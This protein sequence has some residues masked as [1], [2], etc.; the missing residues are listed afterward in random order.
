[1][2]DTIRNTIATFEYG[3][4]FTPADFPVDLRKQATVNRVL[5]N[6]VAAGQI[7]RAS[8]G[9]FYKPKMT[10]FGELPLNIC[11]LVKDLIEK[12]G[13]TVGYLTGY[14]AFN[15]LGLTTQVPFALQIGVMNEKMAIK[16]NYYRISFI[17]Q[18]NEITKENIYLLQLLDCLRFF[19]NIPDS[20]PN[21]T[22]RRLFLLLKKLDKQQREE[23]KK[24]SLKYTP[25]ATAL[26]GAILETLNPKEDTNEM[27]NK[28]NPQ[29]FYK[30]GISDNILS[31][32]K[33]WNI[34]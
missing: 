16:R 14:T 15:E 27:Y 23:I 12:N 6:M 34:R 18:Q 5:N 10:E 9:R 11:Q 25:Q 24:L 29:T 26:L 19:K 28:L 4:V 31:N 8:K 17:K 1:M 32:Q 33:K 13:K 21:E 22:C 2:T 30:L 3:F 7:R 20:M